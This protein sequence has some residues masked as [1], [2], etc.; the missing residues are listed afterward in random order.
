LDREVTRIL[1]V[2]PKISFSDEFEAS[3][4]D[5]AAQRALFDTMEGLA[6]RRAVTGPRRMVRTRPLRP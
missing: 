2:A 3:R 1:G 6:D 4:F 5:L